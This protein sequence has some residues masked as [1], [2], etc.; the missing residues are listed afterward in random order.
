MALHAN[1]MPEFA[2]L[3]SLPQGQPWA[4]REAYRPPPQSSPCSSPLQ[5][6]Y[7]VEQETDS[8]HGKEA[9][10]D[11]SRRGQRCQSRSLPVGHL[12][13]Q[14]SVDFG[15]DLLRNSHDTDVDENI[16]AD[17]A[18]GP[19]QHPS[20]RRAVHEEGSMQFG[21][22]SGFDSPRAS[23]DDM[24][25][26]PSP[27][28]HAHSSEKEEPG[29][30]ALSFGYRNQVFKPAWPVLRTRTG[31]LDP[32][33]NVASTW[34]ALSWE[35]L[36]AAMHERKPLATVGPRREKLTEQQ[37]RRNHILHEKKRRA[38]IKEGFDDLLD[39]VPGVRD[40]GLS[41]SAILLRA[42]EWL[43]G[44][45]CENKALRAQARALEG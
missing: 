19:R 4:A 21:S 36:G 26:E 17:W 25:T 32:E 39:L 14:S 30:T 1:M 42:A 28:P 27:P 34:R 35:Y 24:E 22:D 44:L 43:S 38:L 2:S 5:S 20:G 9:G 13:H 6:Q 11:T 3:Q 23:G 12:R 15:E 16:F 37:K 40:R 10:H 29:F 33:A 31:S 8:R 41:K 18:W 7:N 45:V